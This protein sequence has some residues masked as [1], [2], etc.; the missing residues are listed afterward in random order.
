MNWILKNSKNDGIVEVKIIVPNKVFEKYFFFNFSSFIFF[1]YIKLN[2]FIPLI[3]ITFQLI[4]WC[5]T[6]YQIIGLNTI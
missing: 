3:Q 5:E 4:D 2:L 1:N 6:E